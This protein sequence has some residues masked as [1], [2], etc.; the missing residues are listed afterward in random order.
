M[1]TNKGSKSN[2]T[3]S[4]TMEGESREAYNQK[5]YWQFIIATT[6]GVLTII[7]VAASSYY[8]LIRF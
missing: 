7:L 6:V 3:D 8:G 1:K 2:N 5:S 4:T